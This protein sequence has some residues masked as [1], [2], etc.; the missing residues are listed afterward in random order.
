MKTLIVFTFINNCNLL[1]IEDVYIMF[2]VDTF[3]SVQA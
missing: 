1:I 3:K 2:I